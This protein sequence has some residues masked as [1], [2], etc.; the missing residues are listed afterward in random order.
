MI[1]FVI[2]NI[3]GMKIDIFLKHQVLKYKNLDFK[4]T[5]IFVYL[6]LIYV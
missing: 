3:N 6:K 4:K 5:Y 2:L 1:Q